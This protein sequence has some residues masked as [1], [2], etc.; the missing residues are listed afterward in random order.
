MSV[1][2]IYKK[3]TLNLAKSV[4]VVSTFVAAL[5]VASTVEAEASSETLVLQFIGQGTGAE[6]NKLS[7]GTVASMQALSDANADFDV[8]K[9]AGFACFEVD[10]ADPSSGSVI[11]VGTDC[12]APNVQ[13]SSD[14]EGAGV[15]VEAYSFFILPGGAFV[16]TGMTTAR[17]FY[18]GIGDAGGKYTHVTGSVPGSDNIVAGTGQFS[19]SGTVR[20]SGVV[21]MSQ[22]GAGIIDFNCLWIVEV[23][24]NSSN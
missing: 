16:S 6:W 23:G 17:P 14:P 21:N 9:L 15:I 19:D 20:V 24:M 10:L 3:A 4:C 12:L 13:S 2:S 22:F 8:A 18:S 5:G 7:A 1:N 11:G